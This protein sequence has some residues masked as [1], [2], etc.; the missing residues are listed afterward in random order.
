MWCDVACVRHVLAV[1]WRLPSVVRR[2]NA[3]VLP[4]PVTHLTGGLRAGHR[5]M[6]ALRVGKRFALL[7]SEKQ[8]AADERR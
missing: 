1:T 2:L 4:I 6:P 8:L 5:P 7:S 3:E